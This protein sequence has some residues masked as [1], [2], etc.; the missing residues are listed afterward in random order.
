MISRSSRKDRP[1]SKIHARPYW[2][3]FYCHDLHSHPNQNS[4][5]C[6]NDTILGRPI[7]EARPKVEKVRLGLCATCVS[8]AHL[9]SARTQAKLLR[10]PE[11]G[12]TVNKS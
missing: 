11:Q 12:D 2:Y 5:I 8:A 6:A 10:G 1:A 4:V 7:Q 3:L 9:S